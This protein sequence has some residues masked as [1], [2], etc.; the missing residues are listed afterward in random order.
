M[1]FWKSSDPSPAPQRK[2]KNITSELD[3]HEEYQKLR[4]VILSGRMRQGEQAGIYLGPDDAVALGY[5]WP[6][7]TATD[8]IRRLVKSMGLEADYT[9][10]KYE[11]AT[12][13]VWFIRVTYNPP[14]VK[15]AQPHAEQPSS[16]KRAPGRPRKTA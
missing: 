7:R 9:V 15:S 4:A 5:K 14:M 12:P 3:K 11:T 8:S 1:K 6:W 2:R 10:V 16:Q 13:G